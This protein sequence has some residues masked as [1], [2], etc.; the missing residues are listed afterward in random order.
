MCVCVYQTGIAWHRENKEVNC[1]MFVLPKNIVFISL[2]SYL[3]EYG[4]YCNIL[5]R[6]TPTTYHLFIIITINYLYYERTN[7]EAQV[8]APKN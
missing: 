3:A 7:Y 6:H 1:C 8:R 5:T 4:S 2:E